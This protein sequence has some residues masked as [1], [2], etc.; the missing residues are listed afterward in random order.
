MRKIT[1]GITLFILVLGLFSTAFAKKVRVS[2]L[3]VHYSVGHQMV[4]DGYCAYPY[5]RPFSG[6]LD[7]MTVAV[8]SDTAEIVFRDYNM[9]YEGSGPISDTIQS[10]NGPVRLPDYNYDLISGSY[11]RMKIWNSWDGVTNQFAGFVEEFWNVPGKE[12]SV[13]WKM[14]REHQ[15]PGTS[16]DSATEHYDLIMVK[17]PYIC[18]SFMTPAQAD[19]IRTF[20]EIVRDSA[21]NH[22]E[23]RFCLVFGTPRNLYDTI[24]DSAQAKI[25]YELATWFASDSFFVHENEGPYQNLWKYD[26]YRLLCE[27]S[28]GAINRY[29]LKSEYAAGPG[30][31][32]LSLEGARVSQDSLLAFMRTAI[33]DILI[34]KGATGGQ[35]NQPPVLAP[36]GPQATNA[37]SLLRFTVSSTDAESVPMLTSSAPPG[38]A[39]FVDHGDGTGTFD[40][41]PSTHHVGAHTVTFHAT[42]D[43]AAVDSET[44]AITV[45]EIT[46]NEPPILYPIGPRLVNEGSQLLFTVSATDTESIPT[47]TTSSLPGIAQFDDCGD[48]TGTFDWTP[49]FSDAGT[50]SVTFYATDDSLAVDSELVTITVSD[51][52]TNQPPDLNPIS[53]Q[54][55]T[56]NI[57]IEFQV[58]ATDNESVP[59][60]TASALPEGAAFF[61]SG[62]G[63]G[64]FAWRP[65]YSQAGTYSITFYATDDSAAVDSATV[66]ITVVEAGN[67]APVLQPIGAREVAVSEELAFTVSATDPDPGYPFLRANPL[68]GGA[69]FS[70]LGNGLGEFQ[71]TPN[72]SQVGLHEVTFYALDEWLGIDSEIVDITVLN[73]DNEPPGLAAI[74]PK[75]VDENVLLKFTVSATDPDGTVPTVSATPLPGSA[76]FVDNGNGTGVF[77]WTPSFFDAGTYAVTFY[78]DDGEAPDSE[79]VTIGV[80]DVNRPPS[81]NAVGPQFTEENVQLAFTVSAEDP[82]STT[83]R[84]SVLGL[85]ALAAFTDNGDGTGWFEWTPTYEQS[86]TYSVRFYAV[87]EM[88][89]SVIDSETVSITVVNVNRPPVLTSI[90]SQTVVETEELIFTVSAVDPDGDVPVMT[91]VDLPSGAIFIDNGDGTGAFNWTPG[92]TQEGVYNV[93]FYARDMYS[94]A[95]SET[96]TILVVDIGNRAPVLAPI[97]PQS[98]TENVALSFSVSA[99]DPDATVPS[100]TMSNLPTGAV[101]IDHGNGTGSFTWTPTFFQSGDYEVVVYADDGELSDS[102]VVGITVQDA[103]N[104]LPVLSPI[105]DTS[106]IEGQELSFAVS[107]SDIESTPALNASP[108]PPGASFVDNGDSTGSFEWTPVTGQAG[109]YGITFSAVDDSSAADSEIVSI[110]VLEA[111]AENIHVADIVVDRIA[112]GAGLWQAQAFVTIADETGSLVQGAVV[113]G[114]FTRSDSRE[115][116]LPTDANG[117]TLL[118]SASISN[119]PLDWCFRVISVAKAGEVYDENQNDVTVACESG[120]VA[121]TDTEGF[122][123]RHNRASAPTQYTLDQNHPNPFNPTTA[124]SFGLPRSSYV[125]L[126]IYNV[127]GQLVAELVHDR[128]AAGYHTYEWDASHVASGVYL[129]RLASDEYVD[130]KK[131]LL[132]K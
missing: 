14:F 131:M 11:N 53:S 6:T 4:Y 97:G 10:C 118:N 22:P 35:P 12:D 132:L 74:G 16:G 129:Y 103:G 65:D 27:T 100:L 32:H 17:N 55:T 46:T 84:M 20:Y 96:V 37:G 92:L 124:I 99:T 50:Y 75:S 56:E 90:G 41:T 36:I 110:T 5:N 85:P 113:Y 91:A 48:G 115:M 44:V 127:A 125:S 33:E 116:S 130:T 38:G 76:S 15:V 109:D 62:S 82:D 114:F 98:T 39:S 123:G 42:D 58:S 19:S 88:Y 67:D 29:C 1:S 28:A 18:W 26:S 72:A 45:S 120:P 106:V 71:W 119:P 80:N 25:T 105:G 78:A 107:A 121:K 68:P 86:G 13:F 128:L 57:P 108:L 52:S 64:S 89:S 3:F 77:D 93:R 47:L 122:D 51:V 117:A 81:L 2:L 40:W 63:T 23:T 83:P 21:A 34:I 79:V 111:V 61:D 73:A 54:S 49:S 101:F 104:Q 94:A 66:S 43:S 9:N 70:R 69:T 30:N 126:R 31:S 7:T 24:D 8:G 102:E 95:D 112:V 59:E 87:D 60:L